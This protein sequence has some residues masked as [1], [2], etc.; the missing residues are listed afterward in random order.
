MSVVMQVICKQSVTLMFKSSLGETTIVDITNN[1]I[2]I[3]TAE[4]YE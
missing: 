3:S 2:N 4:L 1:N